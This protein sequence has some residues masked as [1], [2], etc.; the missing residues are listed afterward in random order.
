DLVA[1]YRGGGGR[2]WAGLAGE[3]RRARADA[4]E[5]EP[6]LGLD[7]ALEAGE[8]VANRRFLPRLALADEL[9]RALEDGR[10]VVGDSERKA[11]LQRFDLLLVAGLLLGEAACDLGIRV[12]PAQAEGHPTVLVAQLRSGQADGS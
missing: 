4:G 8:P 9:G 6:P 3:V 10:V 11:G 7:P 5:V 2:V 12:G 1:D